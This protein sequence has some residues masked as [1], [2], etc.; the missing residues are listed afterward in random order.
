LPPP[1]IRTEPG[2]RP[3]PPTGPTS[4]VPSPSRPTTTPRPPARASGAWNGTASTPA[5]TCSDSRSNSNPGPSAAPRYCAPAGAGP[6][7]ATAAPTSNCTGSTLSVPAPPGTTSRPHKHCSTP[8]AARVAGAPARTRTVWSSTPPRPTSRPWTTVS[9][10]ST[11]ASKSVTSL[12]PRPRIVSL[13]PTPHRHW[14]STTP[15]PTPAQPP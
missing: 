6:T 14:S 12:A 8:E 7:T 1:R 4:T 3:K 15:P 13:S 2:P 9:P 10:T 5:G 11:Y